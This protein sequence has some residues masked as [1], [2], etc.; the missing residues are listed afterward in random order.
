MPSDVIRF[1]IAV[2]VISVGLA[3]LKGDIGS[4]LIFF[5]AGAAVFVY[6]RVMVS[7]RKRRSGE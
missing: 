7:R 4:G 1:W 5:V 3:W 6:W 2:I